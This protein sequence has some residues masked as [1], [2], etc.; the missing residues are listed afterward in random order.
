MGLLPAGPAADGQHHAGGADQLHRRAGQRLPVCGVPVSGQL[1]RPVTRRD[2]GA[3]LPSHIHSTA[4]V[5]YYVTL[6]RSD[7]CIITSNIILQ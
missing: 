6:N 1:Y 7:I 5:R 2:A 3:D 4:Q